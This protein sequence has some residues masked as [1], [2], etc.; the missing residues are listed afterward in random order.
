MMHI[1]CPHCGLRDEE[2]FCYGGPAH[3]VRPAKP[4]DATDT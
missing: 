2:E 3:V 4:E 1:P